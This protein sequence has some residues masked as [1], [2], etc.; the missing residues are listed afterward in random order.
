M[1]PSSLENKLPSTLNFS[2][3]ADDNNSG[4]G[5][6]KGE[7]EKS[8]TPKSQDANKDE[9]SMNAQEEK[10]SGNYVNSQDDRST[11]DTQAP[12]GFDQ[13]MS[14]GSQESGAQTD[15][16][17]EDCA[18]IENGQMKKKIEELE[19]EIEILESSNVVLK[20]EIMELQDFKS[21]AKQAIKVRDEA[22]DKFDK[23][24]EVSESLMSEILS[25]REALKKEDVQVQ[26]ELNIHNLQQ[27]EFTVRDA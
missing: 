2:D 14:Q 5:K 18:I 3:L 12:P 11:Q 7:K 15:R 23:Q 4:E 27:W 8:G 1:K 9:A 21:M 20:V 22:L 13:G 6:E 17:E 16:F 24:K 10:N 25:Q 19:K 26:T